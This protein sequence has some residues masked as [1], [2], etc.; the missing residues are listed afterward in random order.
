MLGF[1]DLGL[2]VMGFT[3]LSFVVVLEF[4]V[5]G[6]RGFE[7]YDGVWALAVLRVWHFGF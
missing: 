2:G 3:D 6:S 5:L 4:R 1:T 7:I